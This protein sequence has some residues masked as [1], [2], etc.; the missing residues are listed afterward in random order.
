MRRRQLLSLIAATVLLLATVAGTLAALVW[1][2]PAF[3]R[4]TTLPEGPRRTAQAHD[5]HNCLQNMINAREEAVWGTEFTQEMVNSYLQ[6]VGASEY[7][8]FD[9]PDGV[10]AQRVALDTDR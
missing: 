5:F 10:S 4:E 6:D 2:E 7:R 1:Y 3:Y 8:P 9:L